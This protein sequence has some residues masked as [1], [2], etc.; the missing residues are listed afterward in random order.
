MLVVSLFSR[1]S[2]SFMSDGARVLVGL[3]WGFSF[4]LDG[5]SGCLG[6]LIYPASLEWCSCVSVSMVKAV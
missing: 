5:V 2:G 3:S 1:R 6:L 4:V